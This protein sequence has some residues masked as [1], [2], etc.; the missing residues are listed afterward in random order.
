MAGLIDLNGLGHFKAKENAMVADTYSASKT[1]A[2]GDYV[3]YNG[4][5]YRCTTAISTTEA[6]TAGHWTAVKLADD[7]SALKTA[8]TQT[9]KVERCPIPYSSAGNGYISSETG[10]I[11]SA[12]GYL[13]TDYIDLTKYNSI[14][15]ERIIVTGTSTYYYG[16]AFYDSTKTYISGIRPLSN[17]QTNGYTL[18]ETIIPINAVYARFSYFESVE[19]Y[20][21]FELYGTSKLVG[22]IANS[23]YNVYSEIASTSASC[24][25]YLAGNSSL[26]GLPYRFKEAHIKIIHPSGATSENANGVGALITTEYVDGTTSN[27]L[28]NTNI[29]PQSHTS[30]HKME[31]DFH[32]FTTPYK[33]LGTIDYYVDDVFS[34]R[35]DVN[36]TTAKEINRLFAFGGYFN[37]GTYSKTYTVEG[38]LSASPNVVVT[39]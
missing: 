22:A 37:T 30:A 19:T 2:V 31:L 5:L 9:E 35:Y 26:L 7:C 15:Y 34:K 18:Y 24:F 39:N 21:T 38:K 11:V 25:F 8:L 14:T 13:H 4:T 29:F 3:Y 16:I 23:E 33:V 27:A 32:V 12:Q 20:G 10:D 1:Y 17:Q 28:V 36:I 6:W